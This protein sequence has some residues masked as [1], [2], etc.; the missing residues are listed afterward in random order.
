M[1]RRVPCDAWGLAIGASKSTNGATYAAI[2]N[3]PSFG[4]DKRGAR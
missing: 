2:A 1:E 3:A 4:M